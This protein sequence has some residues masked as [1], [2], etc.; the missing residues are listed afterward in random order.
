[1]E[2]TS[3][4]ENKKKAHTRC[5]QHELGLSIHQDHEKKKSGFINHLVIDILLYQDKNGL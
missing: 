1:M 5:L 3:A 4:C 2:R